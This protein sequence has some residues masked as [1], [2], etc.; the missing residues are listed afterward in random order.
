MESKSMEKW[1]PVTD[2]CEKAGISHRRMLRLLESGDLKGE[3]VGDEWNVAEESVEEW[4]A[5]HRVED[6][7][8]D[9]INLERPDRATTEMLEQVLA[10]RWWTVATLATKLHVTADAVRRWSVVGVPDRFVPVLE[11][12]LAGADELADTKQLADQLIGLP[13]ARAWAIV[14]ATEREW[15]DI[16]GAHMV[17][18]D[19]RT[20][21][22]RVSIRDGVVRKASGG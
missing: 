2:A 18:A 12:M 13:E 7:D 21:R 5:A 8:L 19:L 15:E 4:M 22:I 9:G 1:I 14:N 16:T 10:L 20:R 11:Q 6:R 3:Q 17:T